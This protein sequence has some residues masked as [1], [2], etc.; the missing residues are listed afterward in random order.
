MIRRTALATVVLA[1]AVLGACR[2]DTPGATAEADADSGTSNPSNNFTPSSP[3]GAGDTITYSFHGTNTSA[4]SL[5]D[6]AV[7]VDDDHRPVAQQLVHALALIAFGLFSERTRGKDYPALLFLL[8][9]AGL[10][11]A[12]FVVTVRLACRRSRA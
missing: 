7:T 10:S 1:V 2:D 9:I 12:A 3:R 11:L 5:H 6:V 8:A 4:V